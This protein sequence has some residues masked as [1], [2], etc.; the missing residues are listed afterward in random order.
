M[1]N[2]ESQ[3]FKEMPSA[4][5]FQGEDLE[6]NDSQKHESLTN[7]NAVSASSQ[8]K[9]NAKKTKKSKKSEAKNDRALEELK[10]LPPILMGV[11]IT[12]VISA[13]IFQI[14]PNDFKRPV[15]LESFTLNFQVLFYI[16][17]VCFWS[18]C[19]A[20]LSEVSQSILG[21]KPP[22]S[23]LQH[24]ILSVVSLLFIPQLIAATYSGTALSMFTTPRDAIW[25][26]L[27]FLWPIPFFNLF[28]KQVSPEKEGNLVKSILLSCLFNSYALFTLDR[29][30]YNNSLLTYWFYGQFACIAY[31]KWNLR[32]LAGASKEKKTRQSKA[33]DKYTY[34]GNPNE[35]IIKYEPFPAITRWRR[36]QQNALQS[37]LKNII[38][39]AVPVLLAC[40]FLGLSFLGSI[41]KQTVAYQNHHRME[42]A[43]QSKASKLREFLLKVGMDFKPL[44]QDSQTAALKSRVL[45]FRVDSYGRMSG[46]DLDN[47]DK[48][49]YENKSLEI[50]IQEKISLPQ[51]PPFTWGGEL[52]LTM[53][54]QATQIVISC[55]DPDGGGRLTVALPLNSKSQELKAPVSEI[56]ESANS[57]FIVFLMVG[58]SALLVALLYYIN[59]QATHIGISENGW[60]FLWRSWANYRNGPYIEW[61]GISRIFLRH[62]KGK[63]AAT[64]GQLCFKTH[65]DQIH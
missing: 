27:M 37:D 9:G 21:G 48:S 36:Q 44:L 31:L 52:P 10:R 42:M 46:I 1:S 34:A 30:G 25:I 55:L 13:I 11:F 54:F 32:R 7:A 24:G 23:K 17:F 59:N 26:L 39:V 20:R 41:E 15:M 2:F 18:F 45:R 53:E 50:A 49:N 8:I 61:D 63:T 22:L 56:D 28:E 16:P 60:R 35:Y 64:N 47:L 33:Q 57:R 58:G 12:G 6:K 62:E 29:Y 51:P 3:P 14:A 4:K 40:Y 65:G 43:K 5:I 19:I 38:I